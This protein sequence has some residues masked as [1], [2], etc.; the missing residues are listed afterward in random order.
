MPS[1]KT[2]IIKFGSEW[3]PD[4]R[5]GLHVL[6]LGADGRFE[7]ENRQRGEE[8]KSSGSLEPGVLREV[9]QWLGASGFPAVPAHN[10]PPGSSLVELAV[11]R[12]AGSET[13]RM[14]YFAALKFPGYADLVRSLKSWTAWLQE[15]GAADK[16]PAGLH[17]D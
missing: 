15:G 2:L 6:R 1:W 17:R 10:I 11:E 8:K 16:A 14:D 13:A 7:Y 4:S 9:D 5:T 12:D 3:A